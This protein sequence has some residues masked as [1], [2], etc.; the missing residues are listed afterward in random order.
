MEQ[1]EDIKYI[2]HSAISNMRL[3]ERE[4]KEYYVWEMEPM[5][6]VGEDWVFW[7]N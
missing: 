6:L 3:S 5:E 1:T 7:L 2:I 4:K